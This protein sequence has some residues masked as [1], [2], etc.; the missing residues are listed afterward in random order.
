[1]LMKRLLSM[2]LSAAM[3]VGIYVPAYA[4][5]QTLNVIS[6]QV[7]DSGTLGNANV[8]AT[9]MN[10][11]LNSLSSAATYTF[12]ANTG[13]SGTVNLND[14]RT[15]T[16]VDSTGQFMNDETI[17][18]VITFDLKD[19]FEITR[20]DVHEGYHTTYNYLTAVSSIKVGETSENMQSVT[21]SQE[22]VSNDIYLAHCLMLSK[23]VKGR[24]VEITLDIGRD[25]YISEIMI[26]GNTIPKNEQLGVLSGNTFTD[27]DKAWYAENKSLDLVNID[28]D[29]S[30]FW[31]GESNKSIVSSDDDYN[32]DGIDGEKNIT[33]GNIMSLDSQHIAEGS[34]DAIVVFDLGKAC[35]VSRVDVHELVN[36]AAGIGRIMVYTGNELGALAS[37]KTTMLTYAEGEELTHRANVLD[38][39]ATVEARYVAVRML[40]ADGLDTTTDPTSMKLGE[41]LVI[42]SEKEAAEMTDIKILSNQ[43]KV[44]PEYATYGENA[45]I[46]DTGATYSYVTQ[47][48]YAGITVVP[49][50]ES[51]TAGELYLGTTGWHVNQTIGVTFDLKAPRRV[52][53]LDVCYQENQWNGW[54]TITVYASDS[55]ENL[56][57]DANIV[58]VF[59]MKDAETRNYQ[60]VA[61]YTVLGRLPFTN[62]FEAQHIGVILT[63]A[64][65]PENSSYDDTTLRQIVIIGEDSKFSGLIKSINDALAYD[66]WVPYEPTDWAVLQAAIDAGDA[67]LENADAAEAA[68]AK[69]KADI[70]DAIY[71][72]GLRGGQQILSQNVMSNG[73]WKFYPER[74]PEIMM[75]EL[76]NASVRYMTEAEDGVTNVDKA[77]T[78]ITD[79]A[80]NITGTKEPA[81]LLDG[82]PIMYS[83]DN[84]IWSTWGGRGTTYVLFD[85]GEEC[86]I[87]G[88]DIVT[89]DIRS[90]FSGGTNK[91]IG[92][93]KVEVSSDGK[94]FTEAGS[95]VPEE[96]TSE[97]GTALNRYTR[98]VFPAQRGRYARVSVE[99]ATGAIQY[100][101]MEMHVLG[102]QD[103]TNEIIMTEDEENNTVTA[104]V[105]LDG[106]EDK[107]VMFVA[108]YDRLGNLANVKKAENNLIDGKADIT[109]TAPLADGQS[110]K[111][112]VFDGMETI[113]PLTKAKETIDYTECEFTL[114][115]VFSDDGVLQ[116]GI[117]VP[118]Y[119]TAT[120]GTEVKVTI[121]NKEYKT[122]TDGN[123]DWKILADEV[124]LGNSY[125]ITATDGTT[126]FAANN[127]LAGDV[128]VCS[129]QS[130]M[131]YEFYRLG[132]EELPLDTYQNY[133]NFRFLYMPYV[134]ASEEPLKNVDNDWQ[135][136]SELT[137]EELEK[138]SCLATL[139]GMELSDY[140]GGNVPVGIISA[141]RGGT[142]IEGFISQEG[143][144]NGSVNRYWNSAEKSTLFNRMINPITDYGIK[145]VFWYQ[146]CNNAGTME[147]GAYLKLQMA[148]VDDWRTRWGND[149]LPFII[150]QLSTN[151]GAQFMGVRE[152]QLALRDHVDNL[153]VITT[154]DLGDVTDEDG[155]PFGGDIH[156]R[157]KKEVAR[158][159]VLAAAA[160]AYGDTEAEYLFPVIKSATILSD[161]SVDVVFDD[162]YDGLKM[163]DG[164]AALSGFEL[165]LDGTIYPATATIKSTNTINVKVEGIKKPDAVRYGYYGAPE[166]ELNLFNSADIV[167]SPFNYVFE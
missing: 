58:E 29:V 141:A 23:A 112:M 38:F 163:K 72:L 91:Y 134:P 101:L 43:A 35:N 85:F 97:Y 137:S 64:N 133:T 50:F 11:T 89:N 94:S 160:V 67:L 77:I 74:W 73:D 153:A 93:L 130:N 166:P 136:V 41:I 53:R 79:S 12:A 37:T 102:R 46:I 86:W 154:M 155:N 126:T 28:T 54:E 103:F 5:T 152:Q 125:D 99:A 18:Y 51:L 164:D 143:L 42:G 16:P 20:V 56:Y 113:K 138:L 149:E 157:E 158:R 90:V 150:T 96:I 92:K 131:E 3:L 6:G 70:D 65:A 135:K 142:Y 117:K 104:N 132:N 128:W 161:G 1:M 106:E 98:V 31:S 121:A 151:A 7:L 57:Q 9:Y 147:D 156:P 32:K 39:G 66:N 108:T 49:T 167:A 148:L 44:P 71:N 15:W 111:G 127:M 146:G 83:G 88:A 30:Y 114:S 165:V 14:G 55:A 95:V 40:L 122:L 21:V 140:L 19:V 48:E 159:L 25:A 63:N 78:H 36:A 47:D 2:M 61:Q 109:L 87:N 69:A 45:E 139:T 110:A 33:D 81:E 107:S 80:G 27:S 10:A 162:V 145:G 116:R 119:G 124:T 17:D 26:F 13:I 62:S 129:G 4:E 144:K 22:Q 59:D 76:E 52:D 123:G 75:P 24:Y 120:T 82:G 84:G 8:Y 115:G 105:V 34:G 100:V 60:E 68:I 118:I